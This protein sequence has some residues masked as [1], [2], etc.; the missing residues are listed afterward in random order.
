MS[1]SAH[2]AA[3]Q[4]ASF[5]P[6][7]LVVLFG[8]RF[9]EPAGMLGWKEEVMTS[10]TKV[11]SDKL[12]VQALAAA[13]LAAEQAGSVAL[14]PRSRKAM[15]GL[16]T[17]QALHVVPAGGSSSWPAGT[18][19]AAVVSEAQK[20][21]TVQDLFTAVIGAESQSAANRVIAMVKAGLAARDLLEVE[22]KKV[23]KVFTTA[24]FTLPAATRA[25]AER[26]PLE[27][28]RD[29]L[30]R[31]QQQ[32]PDVWKTVEKDIRAA[33]VWMTESSND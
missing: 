32:R 12:A 24:K 27:P 19:E 31:F 5:T 22:E 15:F 21:P 17:K 23:L 20:Q 4:A 33:L 16:V 3:G 10:G 8:D 28:V 1:T 30:G 13:L 9:A 2:E 29:L 18:L 11:S 14:E 7:E 6:S 25:A 26:A